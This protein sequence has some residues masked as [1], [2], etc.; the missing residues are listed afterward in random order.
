MPSHNVVDYQFLSKQDHLPK[1]I[2]H[3]VGWI[4]LKYTLHNVNYLEIDY[5]SY[6]ERTFY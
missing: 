4:N 2:L 1:D 6:D 5:Y 3:Y